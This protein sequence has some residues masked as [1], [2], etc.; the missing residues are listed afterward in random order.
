MIENLKNSIDPKFTL[1]SS[2]IIEILN[3]STDL[4][5]IKDNSI[6]EFE[7]FLYLVIYFQIIENSECEEKISG[8]IHEEHFMN[9][10]K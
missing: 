8:N 7:I 3:R 6:E 2:K 4:S 1:D 9:V 5:K 10:L